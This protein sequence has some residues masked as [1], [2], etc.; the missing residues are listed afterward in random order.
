MAITVVPNDLDGLGQG[1]T[2]LF[3]GL[4]ERRD[5]P[6]LRQMQIQDQLLADPA[7][8]EA[9]SLIA[10]NM[11]EAG[12]DPYDFLARN[13]DIS[14]AMADGIVNARFQSVEEQAAR[15]MAGNPEAVQ[16]AVTAAET[17]RAAEISGNRAEDAANRIELE[18]REQGIANNLGTILAEGDIMESRAALQQAGYNEDLFRNLNE[19]DGG[20][21]QAALQLRQIEDQMDALN[22]SETSRRQ[23]RNFIS[24]MPPEMRGMA[25]TFIANPNFANYLSQMEQL[26]M[27]QKIALIQSQGDPFQQAAAEVAL[28]SDLTQ[29]RDRL[30]TQ[31]E[32]AE[33]DEERAVLQQELESLGSMAER[34]TRDGLLTRNMA[35]VG[36]EQTGRGLLGN[37]KVRETIRTL[38]TR[39][40]EGV[41]RVLAEMQNGATFE[42]LAQSPTFQQDPD[43]RQALLIAS[44]LMSDQR[45]E[46]VARENNEEERLQARDLRRSRDAVS[47]VGRFGGMR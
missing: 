14:G 20:A 33:T 11:Q 29:E 5:A 24:S 37:A 44:S 2:N 26:D 38:P 47:N 35:L 30:S 17:G 45:T 3:A 13:F 21:R 25:G 16:G 10:Q 34:F 9:L 27:R 31:L 8:M 32:E 12:Q 36:A 23:Y 46:A 18:R 15:Q 42:E 39:V 41:E 43:A 6:R 19:N 7:R 22:L 4:R 1:L 40:Q 28:W